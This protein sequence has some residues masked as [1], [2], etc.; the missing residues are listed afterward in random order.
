M[1]SDNPGR[2]LERWLIQRLRAGLC[3]RLRIQV[4]PSKFPLPVRSNAILSLLCEGKNG[5]NPPLREVLG[6]HR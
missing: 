5:Q 2:N 6:N 1:G 4:L 3:K